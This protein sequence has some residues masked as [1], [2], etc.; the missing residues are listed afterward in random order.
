MAQV[1]VT[2]PDGSKKQVEAGI[3]VDEFVKTQIGAGLA[4]DAVIASDI[5]F[6]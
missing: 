4:K 6:K 1:S 3:R 5:L 2:L